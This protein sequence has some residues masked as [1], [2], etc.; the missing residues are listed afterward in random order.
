MVTSK[1]RWFAVGCV[2]AMMLAAVAAPSQ[3]GPFDWMC[4]SGWSHAGSQPAPS[5]LTFASPYSAYSAQR[6]SW[7]PVA[8]AAVGCDPCGQQK[9][10][11][12]ETKYRW[13][14]SRIPSTSMQAVS[15]CDP[16]TGCA[17]TVYKP[18]TTYSV[19][20]WLH[21]E[22]YTVYRP[23]SVAAAAYNPCGV[24][25]CDPC[26]GTTSTF[27]PFGSACSTCTV[28]SFESSTGGLSSDY[29]PPDSDPGYPTGRTFAPSNSENF[30][31]GTAPY[32]AKR[33]AEDKIQAI[34]DPVIGNPTSGSP[35]K[36]IPLTPSGRTAA[37]PIP[38]VVQ[39]HPA[40]RYQPAIRYPPVAQ[41]HVVSKPL[42][43]IAPVQ[44]KPDVSGWRAVAD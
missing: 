10:Y 20:P 24:N 36:L 23:V 13:K 28:S 40:I 3:A 4:P 38:S 43:P 9:S 25:R 14:Y 30:G 19:L 26:G 39:V 17:T 31:T 15:S 5:P 11:A 37:L 35:P 12:A 42:A 16:T 1:T 22:P 18:V 29:T 32:G 2:V 41:Y 21:R 44:R 34:P 33:E 8:G 7:M 27:A 6:I